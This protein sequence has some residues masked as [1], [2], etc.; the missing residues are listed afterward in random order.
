MPGAIASCITFVVTQPA[1]VN[2]DEMVITPV[3]Q[4][5]PQQFAR[6]PEL[7]RKLGG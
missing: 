2:I 1:H 7:T 6:D 3:Q 4:G 5:A